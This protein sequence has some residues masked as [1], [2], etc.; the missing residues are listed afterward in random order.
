MPPAKQSPLPLQSLGHAVFVTSAALG[1]CVDW[2]VGA[3]VGAPV[4]GSLV[5]SAV[6]KPSKLNPELMSSKLLSSAGD[7]GPNVGVSVVPGSS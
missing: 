6:G 4:E 2:S 5:G 3:V 1:V 7:N